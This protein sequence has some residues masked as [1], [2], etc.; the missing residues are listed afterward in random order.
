MSKN[1][2]ILK[3]ATL[4]AP[5]LLASL[6]LRQSCF[7]G[8]GHME[9]PEATMDMYAQNNIFGYDASECTPKGSLTIDSK[10]CFKVDEDTKAVDFWYGEGCLNT[11]ACKSDSVKYY[12]QGESEKSDNGLVMTKN[13]SWIY[14][15]TKVD[16]D[17]GGMQ[18]IYAKNYDYKYDG[19]NTVLTPNEGNSKTKYYWIVLPDQA[20]TNGFGDTYVATFEKLDNPVYFIVFDAHACAH[21]SEKYCDQAEKDP[22]KVAIGKQFFGSFTKDGSQSGGFAEKAGKL[23]SFCRLKGS[24]EVTVD[25][26]S[27]TVN[28]GNSDSEDKDKE[29]K[30]KDKKSKSK[31]KKSGNGGNSINKKALELAWPYDQ[32]SKAATGPTDA[33]KKAIEEYTKADMDAAGGTWN[34]T[35]RRLGQ[36]C[37]LFVATVMR[38]SGA[39]ENYPIGLPG[40][41]PYVKDN[42]NY[43]EVSSYAEA[44]AGDIAF[45][46]DNVGPFDENTIGTGNGHTWLIVDDNGQKRIAQGSYGD[47]AGAVID[48][49]F[50]ERDVKVFRLKGNDGCNSFS[51]NYPQYYQDD[52][53]GS[54]HDNSNH[55]WTSDKYSKGKISEYGSG[56]TSAAMI[57]TSAT[58]QD[59][60]PQDIVKITSS[61]DPKKHNYVGGKDCEDDCGI[62]LDLK[63]KEE[64][65]IEVKI[66]SY[67]SK[68]DAYDKIKSFLNDGYMVHLAGK[69]KHDGFSKGNKTHYVGLFNIDGDNKVMVANPDSDIGNTQVDLQNIV[70]AINNGKFA[71]I[72][73]TVNGKNACSDEGYCPGGDGGGGG[74]ASKGGAT[75]KQAEIIAHWYNTNHIPRGCCGLMNCVELSNFFVSELTTKGTP[76]GYSVKGDGNMV[77]PNLI[78]DGVTDG[79]NEPRVWSVFSDSGQHT[80]VVVGANG[81]G[82]FITIEAAWGGWW[83]GYTDGAGNARVYPAKSFDSSYTFAYFANHL[84]QDKINQIL[85]D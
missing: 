40:Q 36:S 44:K 14:E 69:G 32:A 50:T 70:D 17:F 58:G 45:Y 2:S 61:G 37:D 26:N 10:S 66:E 18:Y 11:G 82:T 35:T 75:L 23:T 31:D 28:S 84:K 54:D 24:G 71:I 56:P 20:Y 42:E 64:Y 21:Q 81:D 59:V 63:L 38:S 73:G 6:L 80:G 19:S 1:K 13:N 85:N 49:T 53:E 65:D 41:Y 52:Y 5:F 72:K 8:S 47:M 68:T 22:E 48:L 79:G 12:A 27:G 29:S 57:I 16:D 62:E 55:N 34:E 15:D 60:Y 39:D 3:L 83:D 77:A 9:I 7:A 74:T 43:K 76:G 46:S 25:G 51:G 30:S 4:A 33:Y 67:S 78:A